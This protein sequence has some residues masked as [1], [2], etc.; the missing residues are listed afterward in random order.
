[1]VLFQ[2]KSKQWVFEDMEFPGA[3]EKTEPGNST[4]HL[5]KKWNF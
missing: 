5:K 1:M 3:I 4:A 2:K